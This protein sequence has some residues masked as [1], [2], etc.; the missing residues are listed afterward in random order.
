M[1]KERQTEIETDESLF[2]T[3]NK[4]EQESTRVE[5]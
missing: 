4:K 1:I 5:L 3:K 2:N